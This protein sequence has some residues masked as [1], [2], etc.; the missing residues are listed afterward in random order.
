MHDLPEAEKRCAGCRQD[1]RAIG[2]DTRR[3]YE[4]VPAALTVVE[5]VCLKYACA[6]TVH[7]A[8]KPPQPIEKST[9]GA[10]LL[11]QVIVRGLGGCTDGA[12]AAGSARTLV[13][14]GVAPVAPVS[15]G[16]SAGCIAEESGGGGG[17]LHAQPLGGA[18]PLC[19][20]RRVVDRQRGGGASQSR[21]RDRTKQLDVSSAAI[22]AVRLRRCWPASWLPVSGPA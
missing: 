20:R 10:S 12:G 11:A 9:A 5:E 14:A 3:R 15:I 13:T 8:T 7:T 22:R 6:C 18:E 21:V 4:Y 2:D 17:A 19:R 1:L 16:T